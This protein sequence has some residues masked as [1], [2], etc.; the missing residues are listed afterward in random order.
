MLQPRKAATAR[1]ALVALF[2]IA[3][4]HAI[5]ITCYKVHDK[6]GRIT[7]RGPQPPIDLTGDLTAQL[8]KQWGG[9]KLTY[10]ESPFCDPLEDTSSIAAAQPISTASSFSAPLVATESAHEYSPADAVHSRPYIPGAD[11]ATSTI[12]VPGSPPET[13]RSTAGNATDANESAPAFKDAAPTAQPPRT[14]SV[15]T[16]DRASAAEEPAPAHRPVPA[17]SRQTNNSMHNQALKTS[18][19]APGAKYTPLP[20]QAAHEP[21]TKQSD[22]DVTSGSATAKNVTQP[23]VGATQAT[24]AHNGTIADVNPSLGFAWTSGLHTWTTNFN[25]PLPSGPYDYRQNSNNGLRRGAMD[26]GYTYQDRETRGD[27][28]VALAVNYNLDNTSANYKKGIDFHLD[29][30]SIRWYT[31]NW[32]AGIAG[33]VNYQLTSDNSAAQQVTPFKSKVAAIGPQLGY[34]FTLG[35][36]PA[37][38][39]VRG[40]WEFWSEDRLQGYA[41][42]ATLEIPLGTQNK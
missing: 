9:G 15:H 7:Y 19:P 1:I 42:S 5:A 24:E 30:A 29:W 36:L 21:E 11:T 38:A 16:V 13:R 32:Q 40:Y 2:S 23:D 28:S 33:Y 22:N 17:N 8:K 12:A 10:M 18:T 26:A 20:S 41:V 31:A 25:G 39:N 14:A 3:S 4:T 35:S 34:A 27:V 37:Y 6:A